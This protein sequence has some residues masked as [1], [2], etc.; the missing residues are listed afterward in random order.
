MNSH[1]VPINKSWAAF[2]EDPKAIVLWIGVMAD[3]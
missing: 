1:F 2:A 3:H